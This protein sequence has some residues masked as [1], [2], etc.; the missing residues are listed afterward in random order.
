MMTMMMMMMIRCCDAETG[1]WAADSDTSSVSLRAV[2]G[3]GAWS[4]WQSAWNV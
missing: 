2:H 3:D 1:K 4:N